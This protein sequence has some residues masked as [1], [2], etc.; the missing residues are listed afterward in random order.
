MVPR[1]WTRRK[2]L[3]AATWGLTILTMEIFLTLMYRSIM[4]TFTFYSTI[5][6]AV[7]SSALLS[8]AIYISE[9]RYKRARYELI[10]EVLDERVDDDLGRIIINAAKESGRISPYELAK[11]ANLSIYKVVERIHEL[12]KEGKLR[13]SGL[14]LE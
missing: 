4:S 1:V 8:L 9:P 11:E 2:A 6:A 14:T 12:E 7:I 5:A 13:I 10:I 3:V